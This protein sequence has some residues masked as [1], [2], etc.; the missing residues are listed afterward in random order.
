MMLRL[1]INRRSSDHEGYIK[2]IVVRRLPTL[3]IGLVGGIIVGMTSVGSGSLMVVA[4]LFLYPR[5]GANELVG[6]DLTQ[7]V[8]LTLAAASGAL[9]FGHVDL[10]V[11]YALVIGGVPAVIIG[12]L[13]SSQVPDRYVRPVITFVIFISGLKYVGLG[14]TDLGWVA[15]VTLA[16]AIP[17]WAGLSRFQH[18]TPARGA[19]TA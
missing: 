10:A 12:S 2:D 9:L 16:V 5:L 3:L 8:P 11:T 1:A 14:T 19:Q 7:A 15:A 6:T 4:L 13:F 17:A 18:A